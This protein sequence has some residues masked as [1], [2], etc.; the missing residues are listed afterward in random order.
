MSSKR[1]KGKGRLAISL[2]L[3]FEDINPPTLEGLTLH[4][5][6]CSLKTMIEQAVGILPEMYRLTYLDT[7]P[8]E[9]ETSLHDH[10]IISGATLTLYPWRIWSDLLEAAYLG[11]THGCFLMEICGDSKWSKHCA[12]CVLYVASHRGHYNLAAKLLEATSV[13]VNAQS[14][15]GWTALHAASCM[16]QW[17]ALCILLDNGADVRIVDKKGLTAFDLARKHGNKKCEQSLNF[18]LWNLQKHR[19]VQ[20]RQNDYDVTKSRMDATRQAHQY[21]DS[22]LTTWLQGTCG[23][24]YMMQVPNPISVGDVNRFEKTAA[25]PPSE[26]EPP[27]TCSLPSVKSSSSYL[28]TSR[29]YTPKLRIQSSSATSDIAFEK[30]DKGKG[31]KLDFNYGWFDPLRAQQLIPSTNDVLTYS[32]PSSC[33]LRPRSLINPDGYRNPL[34]VHRDERKPAPVKKTTV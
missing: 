9:P 11:D 28:T 1:D 22:T 32:N 5:K 34:T 13:A 3:P 24:R 14:P 25:K 18:C 29:P 23:R 30:K 8:L 7:A 26:K 21:R 20:K 33:K 6:V 12:W 31:E 10:D 17:K 2:E 15:S 4:T 19:I 27:L 16:G